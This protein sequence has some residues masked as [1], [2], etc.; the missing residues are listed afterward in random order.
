MKMG[1]SIKTG[2]IGSEW[3]VNKCYQGSK[4]KTDQNKGKRLPP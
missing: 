4:L 3:P 1:I 2:K